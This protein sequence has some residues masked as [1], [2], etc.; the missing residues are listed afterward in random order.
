MRCVRRSVSSAVLLAAIS[1]LPAEA[2]TFYANGVTAII[3]GDSSIGDLPG[4]YGG[5]P[6]VFPVSLTALQAQN[7]IL[8]APDD[9]FL[10]LPGRDDTPSGSA[11]PYTYAEVSFANN[12]TASGTKLRIYETGDS[13]EQAQIWL[14]VTGGGFIHTLAP[15]AANG[16]GFTEFDLSS[17]A[18][19]LAL[20]GPGAEFNRV[21]VGGLDLLGASQGFDLDAVSVTTAD[22][23]EP[24]TFALIGA[25][26]VAVSLLRPRLSAA[27]VG[28]PRQKRHAGRP[29]TC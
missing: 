28:V 7:A 1:I 16:A 22:A 11:F 23:P 24:A 18:P 4:L 25:G 14:W 12:F 20:F 27:T 6:F 5:D 3:R 29:E 8:G 17:L 26:L 10:S 21:G 15:A 19:T 2:A 13:G 9:Q